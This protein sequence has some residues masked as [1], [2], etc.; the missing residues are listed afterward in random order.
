MFRISWKRPRLKEVSFDTIAI[1]KYWSEKRDK[2][3]NKD[4]YKL[5]SE[6]ILNG[7]PLRLVLHVEQNI[8]FHATFSD[9]HHAINLRNEK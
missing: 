3:K 7:E 9:Y 6:K 2:R 1:F 8:L 5:I 4:D